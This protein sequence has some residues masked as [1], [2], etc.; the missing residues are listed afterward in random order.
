MGFYDILEGYN[1][2]NTKMNKFIA[3]VKMERPSFFKRFITIKRLY[4]MFSHT[5]NDGLFL[6]L[7]KAIKSPRY[8]Y[9]LLRQCIDL[10]KSMRY[11]RGVEMNLKEFVTIHDIENSHKKIKDRKLEIPDNLASKIPSDNYQVVRAKN[12]MKV[13]KFFNSCFKHNNNNYQ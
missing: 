12:I 3:A 13:N 5:Q 7:Y 4:T 9:L 2:V 1:S 11:N 6:Q 10:E 8:S